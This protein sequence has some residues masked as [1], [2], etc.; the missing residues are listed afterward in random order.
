MAVMN[1]AGMKALL[2]KG[3]FKR[4]NR[5]AMNPN[6]GHSFPYAIGLIGATPFQCGLTVLMSTNLLLSLKVL[7]TRHPRN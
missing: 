3:R 2:V 5:Q 7:S 4:L 6:Y 1:D